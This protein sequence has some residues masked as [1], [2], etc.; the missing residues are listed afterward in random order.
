MQV[1]AYWPWVVGVQA[2]EK[3][4]VSND[5]KNTIAISLMPMVV[6]MPVIPPEEVLVAVAEGMDIDMPMSMEVVEV[7][8]PMF[9]TMVVDDPISIDIDISIL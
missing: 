6:S 7:C 8:V 1:P 9:I 3:S 2:S 4:A 5:V